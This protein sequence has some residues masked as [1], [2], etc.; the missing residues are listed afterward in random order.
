MTD[1]NNLP[2]STNNDQVNGAVEPEMNNTAQ[3][4]STEDIVDQPKISIPDVPKT[5]IND[6][7]GKEVSSPEPPTTPIVLPTELPTIT[8]PI[9]NS[10]ADLP[11]TP[12]SADNLTTTTTPSLENL[13]PVLT[14]GT[15]TSLPINDQPLPT[16]EVTSPLTPTTEPVQTATLTPVPISEPT[17]IPTPTGPNI[18]M[19]TPLVPPAPE[20]PKN[21]NGLKTAGVIF[22]VVALL[23]AMGGGFYYYQ[24]LNNQ[25]TIE[26]VTEKKPQIFVAQEVV[27][28]ERKDLTQFAGIWQ[29]ALEKQQTFDDYKKLALTTGGRFQ[30][31]PVLKIGDETLYGNDLNYLALFYNFDDYVASKPIPTDKLNKIVDEAI[32]DSVIIQ[33]A[34]KQNLLTSSAEFFDNS[35]KN[36]TLRNEKINLAKAALSD[37]LVE[38][39][40][41]EAISIWFNNDIVPVSV[42]TGKDLALKKM[43]DLQQKIKSGQM[44]MAQAGE[45]I[46]KDTEIGKKIDPAYANNAYDT[47]TNIEKGSGPFS[48]DNLNE[49]A[50]SLGDGQMSDVVIGK[51]ASSSGEM[52]EDLYMIIKVNKRI[53]ENTADNTDQ[54]VKDLIDQSPK[55]NISL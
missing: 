9:E 47:F 3:N 19:E 23:V 52:V 28:A 4:S 31:V 14:P 48:L 1:N 44:T 26:T 6:D 39:I 30:N 37:K 17:P 51:A 54:L 29:D 16:A 32:S 43:Q 24:N 21:K 34:I 46:K 25:K 33:Q 2:T 27:S 12:V 38:K 53:G 7:N 11:V 8:T 55:E 36:Y 41:G 13:E 40:S 22:G 15:G 35:N 49:E 18:T 50:W 45:T 5:T 42:Q 10:T 20:P